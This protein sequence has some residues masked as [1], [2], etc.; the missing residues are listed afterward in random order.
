MLILICVLMQNSFHS[1]PRENIEVRGVKV[2]I[3]HNATVDQ[4]LEE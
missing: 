2:K 4:Q 1:I 3:P